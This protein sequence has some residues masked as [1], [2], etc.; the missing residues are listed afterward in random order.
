MGSKYYPLAG[1]ID[2]LQPK[3]P[4]AACRARPGLPWVPDAYSGAVMP[5]KLRREIAEMKSIC[6]GCVHLIE[7]R[8]YAMSDASIFGV[9]G[10]LTSFD[11][12][13]IRA[14]RRKVGDDGISVVSDYPGY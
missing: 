6:G 10:G 5:I 9:W 1:E 8:D 4:E 7:C 12:R 3:W 14:G 13:E 11:R 2:N